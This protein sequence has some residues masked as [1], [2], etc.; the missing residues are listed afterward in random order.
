MYWLAL[1]M[2]ICWSEPPPPPVQQAPVG[3]PLQP[4][5][6]CGAWSK[7]NIC[8]RCLQRNA[9]AYLQPQPSAPPYQPQYQYGYTYAQQPQQQ[10]VYYQ[11][12]VQYPPQQRQ[13]GTATAIGAG[14][15][16]GAIMEDILDPTE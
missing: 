11:P 4:C 13:M 7:M 15:L 14:F 9:N 12:P 2:G 10:M 3:I 6:Q 8:E 16:A 5:K 1:E